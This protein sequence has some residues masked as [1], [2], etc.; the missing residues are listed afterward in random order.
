VATMLMVHGRV[1][2]SGVWRADV[3]V[4]PGSTNHAERG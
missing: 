2:A 1:R 4:L 3:A